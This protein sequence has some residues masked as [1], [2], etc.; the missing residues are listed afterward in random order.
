MNKDRILLFRLGGLGDLMVILPGLKLLRCAFPLSRFTLACR[1]EYG[2]LLEKAGLVEEIVDAGAGRLADL[3]SPEARLNPE[4]EAWLKSFD[5]VW[6]WGLQNLG[7]SLEEGLKRHGARRVQ[8]LGPPSGVSQPLF[9]FYFERTAVALR[10]EGNISG[11]S[12]AFD[13]W[14]SQ[15]RTV[16][17]ADTAGQEVII[18]PGSGSRRK[19]WPLDRFLAVTERLSE[20]DIPGLV[21]TGEAEAWLE[22]EL[23]RYRFSSGWRWL[24][25]PEIAALAVRLSGCRFY[26]GNDSGVTHLAAACGAMGLALFMQES[27]ILWKPYG[28][29][30]QLSAKDMADIEMERVWEEL[31]SLL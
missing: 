7:P 28:R 24:P 10:M 19:C 23:S 25:R 1:V 22:P 17:A 4:V 26:L 31:R 30:R 6:V 3:F 11:T 20:S 18:H 21:V 12:Q 15:A 2:R 16:A 14:L 5:Q 29:V 13:S 8:T 27:K 9:Q